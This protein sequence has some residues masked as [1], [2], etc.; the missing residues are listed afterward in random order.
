MSIASQPRNLKTK[1]SKTRTVCPNHF[2]TNF[3]QEHSVFRTNLRFLGAIGLFP[4]KSSINHSNS[5]FTAKINSGGPQGPLTLCMRKFGSKFSKHKN[6]NNSEAIGSSDLKLSQKLLTLGMRTIL[7][8]FSPLPPAVQKL[9]PQRF[10]FK[11]H[12]RPLSGFLSRPQ[13]FA[14]YSITR[15]YTKFPFKTIL[16]AIVIITFV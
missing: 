11:L 3:F 12:S 15:T 7:Q 8:N 13:I 9:S 16:G 14:K 1:L 2:K 6:S 5:N 10:S 4:T